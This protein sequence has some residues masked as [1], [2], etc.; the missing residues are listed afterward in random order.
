MSQYFRRYSLRIGDVGYVPTHWEDTGR[1]PPS[2]GP[3]TYKMESKEAAGCYV[4]LPPTDR[5]DFI[6]R[7]TG[8]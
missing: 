6:R 1:L 7:H 2:G 4:R 3:H 8:G 5:G